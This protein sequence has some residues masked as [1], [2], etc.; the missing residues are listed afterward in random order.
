MLEWHEIAREGFPPE[1]RPVLI[2]L[3]KV[4]RGLPGFEAAQWWGNNLRD[5]CWWTNGGPNAGD[6]M[7][8]WA[9]ATHWAYVP[10]PTADRPAIEPFPDADPTDFTRPWDG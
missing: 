7:D 10:A 8:E 2:W 1:G 9:D 6:D 4:N 3:P 5:G